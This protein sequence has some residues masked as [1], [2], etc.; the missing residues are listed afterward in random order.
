MCP[1][2]DLLLVYCYTDVRMTNDEERTC[3]KHARLHSIELLI[4][5]HRHMHQIYV[6]LVTCINFTASINSFKCLA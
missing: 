5:F 1:L 6:Y 2:L 4:P 3:E